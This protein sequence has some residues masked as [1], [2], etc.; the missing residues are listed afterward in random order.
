MPIL[1]NE[2]AWKRFPSIDRRLLIRLR[3]TRTARI[4]GTEMRFFDAEVVDKNDPK[5]V[6]TKGSF[7]IGVLKKR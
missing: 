6:F 5:T 3:Q 2:S 7:R 4:A 1:K